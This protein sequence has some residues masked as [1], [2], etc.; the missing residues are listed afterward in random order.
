MHYVDQWSEACML[1][2]R[3]TNNHLEMR[4]SGEGGEEKAVGG[5]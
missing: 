4:E 5:V 2:G 3:T 1:R